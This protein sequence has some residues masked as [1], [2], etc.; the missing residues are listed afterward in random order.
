MRKVMPDKSTLRWLLNEKGFTHQQIADWVEETTGVRV[1]TGSVSSAIS[2][3]GLSDQGAR[4]AK[5]LP[6]KVKQEHLMAYPA[7][8]LRLMGRRDAGLRLTEDQ[9][10]RL[11]SWLS[12]L[13]E[14]GAVVVYVPETE[15][16]FHYIVAEP[17]R[18]DI[19]VRE[20]LPKSAS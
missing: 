11:D 19:P 7:R 4:Y 1:A 20:F 18:P 13:K 15:Q 8:M 9:R 2:R 17:D 5:H 14:D 10:E 3:A 12:K 16:G 6:W